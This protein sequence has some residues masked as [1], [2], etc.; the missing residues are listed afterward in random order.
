[1]T[2]T[3]TGVVATRMWNISDLEIRENPHG[4]RPTS[5]HVVVCMYGMDTDV[6][7]GTRGECE[8]FLSEE[9]SRD[10]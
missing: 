1:M 8:N 7:I 10:S 6:F 3:K 4:D 5:S 2:M 9:E